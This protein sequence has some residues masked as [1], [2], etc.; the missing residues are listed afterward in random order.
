MSSNFTITRICQYCGI[1][2]QARTTV[3]RFCSHTC[4]QRFYK[5]QVRQNKIQ[6]SNDQTFAQKEE[7]K[8]RSINREVLKV[9]DVASFLGTTP[10]AV[11]YMIKSAVNLNMR[12]LRVL[13]SELLIFLKRNEQFFFI[14]PEPRLEREGHLTRKNGYSVEEI[15]KIYGMSR[16]AIYALVKSKKIPKLKE[17]SRIYLLRKAVDTIFLQKHSLTG[18]GYRPTSIKDHY[19]IEEVAEKYGMSRGSIYCLLQRKN[20]RRV[21]EGK[22][23]YLLMKDIDEYFKT[24]R[25][26]R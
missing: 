3:T 6:L 4:N 7:S 23:V 18:S 21:K 20:I 5:M 11:Y 2:F 25:A 26:V 8:F 24:R 22:H 17:G 10:R 15:S 9:K 13:R 1:K 16:D 12:L 14:Q 19:S